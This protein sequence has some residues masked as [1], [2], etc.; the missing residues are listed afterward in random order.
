MTGALL[1]LVAGILATHPEG[2][3][4]A[5]LLTVAESVG[6]G[7]RSVY[8][9]QVRLYW[10]EDS[11]LTKEFPRRERPEWKLPAPEGPG[12]V[13]PSWNLSRNTA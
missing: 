12:I 1:L 11:Q 2:N 5:R 13:Y 7:E 9:E 8:P 10:T 6:Q 4:N 3:P